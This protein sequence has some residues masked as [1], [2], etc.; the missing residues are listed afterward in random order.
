[1]AAAEARA[2]AAGGA[3][4]GNGEVEHH[5]SAGA[6]GDFAGGV[7]EGGQGCAAHAPTDRASA[8]CGEANAGRGSSRVALEKRGIRNLFFLHLRKVRIQGW[9][10][11]KLLSDSGNVFLT[12]VLLCWTCDLH[13]NGMNIPDQ[14]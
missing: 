1:M 8:G 9:Y 6:V 5:T 3:A 10:L 2:G 4:L 13:Q 7:E 14:L 12:A 11:S